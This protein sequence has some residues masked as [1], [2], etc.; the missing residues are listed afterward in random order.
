MPHR[1]LAP[2]L[3]ALGPVVPRDTCMQVRHAVAY[4]TGTRLWQC[5]PWMVHPSHGRRDGSA[6]GLSMLLV[7]G[8]ESRATTCPE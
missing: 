2:R 8:V 7:L 4:G 6:S 1:F 5:D 3:T